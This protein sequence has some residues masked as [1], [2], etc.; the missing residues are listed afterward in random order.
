MEWIELAHDTEQRKSVVKAARKQLPSLGA[1]H[2]VI[3]EIR[4]KISNESA[5]SVFRYNEEM[6]RENETS[7]AMKC[8]TPEAGGYF[9]L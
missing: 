9:F 6:P 7:K 1:R 4:T 8:R 3:C 2:S 5:A